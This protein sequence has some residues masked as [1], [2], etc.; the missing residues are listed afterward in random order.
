MHPIDTDLLH[1]SA[2]HD[3]CKTQIHFLCDN[4]LYLK[5]NSHHNFHSP[6]KKWFVEDPMIKVGMLF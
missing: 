5:S 3:P 2:C 1:I 4:S 6:I